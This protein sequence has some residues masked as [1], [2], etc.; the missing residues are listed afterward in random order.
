[1]R[2]S[3]VA[4]QGYAMLYGKSRMKV[5]AELPWKGIAM[6]VYIMTDLEGV[7]GV[8]SFEEQVF[9][10]SRYYEAAKALL[11]AEVNSGVEGLL[12]MGVEDVLICDGHGPGAIMF[13]QLHPAAKLIHGRPLA[14]WRTWE[15]ILKNYDVCMMIGQHAMAGV[16]TANLNHTIN[17]KSTDYIKLNGKLIGEIGKFAL[18]QGAMGTPIIFLSGDEAACREAEELIPGITTVSVKKA[19]GRNSAISISAPEARRRIREGVKQ[20]IRNHQENPVAPLKWEGPFVLE[21]RFFYTDAA[22]ANAAVRGF[23]RVDD[24][25]VRIRSDN[26][27]NVIY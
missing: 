6:K 16:A 11:T 23:E 18:C 21:R 17:S 25:T 27:L 26:I 10:D 4:E 9:S 1:M 5:V 24:Q 3:G 15:H 2:L 7:A 20:A 19:L 13:E 8:V 14:P 22:D 12:E